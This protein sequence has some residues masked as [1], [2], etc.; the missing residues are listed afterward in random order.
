MCEKTVL[1]LCCFGYSI[2]FPSVQYE[3][4]SA[5][6]TFVLLHAKLIIQNI[7]FWGFFCFICTFNISCVFFF[8]FN[9]SKETKSELASPNNVLFLVLIWNNSLWKI[10]FHGYVYVNANTELF[11]MSHI[12][13]EYKIIWLELESREFQ[14]FMYVKLL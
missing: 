13:S 5:T 6:Y 10:N 3:D 4:S 12:L 7:L 1:V 8:S 11:G 2:I 9:Y 14:I